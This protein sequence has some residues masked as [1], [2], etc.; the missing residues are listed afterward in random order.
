[1]NKSHLKPLKLLESGLKHHQ[2][3]EF[4]EAIAIYQKILAVNPLHF[5]ALKLLG[6]VYAQTNK[7]ELALSFIDYA[8]KIKPNNIGLLNNRG[9]ILKEL[10]RTDEALDSYNKAIEIRP[11]YAEAW[12]SRA[13]TLENLKQ[14]DEALTSYKKAITLEPGYTEAIFNRGVM[15]LH[16]L[17]FTDGWVGYEAR[18][19]TKEFN[20]KPLLT[21]KSQW[22]G[23][24]G[25]QRLFIWAEQ[26]I[27][28]QILYGSILNELQNFPNNKIIS[29]DKKLIPVFQRSFSSYQFIDKTEL[30]SEDLYDEQIPIGS[31]GQF[32][33]KELGDFKNT[34]Y[35]YLIDDPIKTQRIKSS[36]PFSNQKTCGISWRSANQKLGKDKSVSLEDLLPILSM[37]DMQ[38]VNLQYGDT[39]EEIAVLSEKHQQSLYSVPEIDIFNDIDGVLSIISACDLIITTS[40]ST[41]HLAGALGKETLLLTPYSVG[42]FWYWHDIDGVSLWYPSV[43]V[44]PQ[45]TQGEWADPINAIKT[46]LE[47][48]DG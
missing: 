18:W 34:A 23:G 12:F 19:H 9:N 13:V 25:E 27:G 4:N 41:A 40:N 17:Q 21:S 1:M 30:L 8:L 20:S 44:F 16:N 31:L 6:T 28:D 7:F 22:H 47:K 36:P 42:K 10:Q 35:P 32:F 3:G 29:V 48:R 24:K 11:D 14:Y 39:A 38:F 46:Y 33:R 5:D 26:G 37:N 45:T 15:Q 2:N 43:R